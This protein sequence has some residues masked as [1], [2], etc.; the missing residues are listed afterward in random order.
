MCSRNKLKNLEECHL[1]NSRVGMLV[2][3]MV[4]ILI[5]FDARK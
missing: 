4:K 1:T 3:Q 2:N 5:L